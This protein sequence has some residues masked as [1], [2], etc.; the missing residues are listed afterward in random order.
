[1][2]P[3]G[4]TSSNGPFSVAIA[5]LVYRSVIFWG[6]YTFP[7][8]NSSQLLLKPSLKE[9]IVFQPSIFRCYVSFGEGKIP[10]FHKVELRITS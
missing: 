7:E 9:G 10:S 4:N 2:E 3:I 1:M 5:L 8:T 6:I